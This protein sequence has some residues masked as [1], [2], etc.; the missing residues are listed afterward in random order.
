MGNCPKPVASPHMYSSAEWVCVHIII[1][2][3]Y[4]EFRPIEGYFWKVKLALE[5]D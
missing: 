4:R 1:L 3:L 2:H 5:F